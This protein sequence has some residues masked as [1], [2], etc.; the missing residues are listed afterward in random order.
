MFKKILMHIYFT[1]IIDDDN[2]N[3]TGKKEEERK[4]SLFEHSSL[5]ETEM[6]IKQLDF[7]IQSQNLKKNENNVTLE[8][9]NTVISPLL[10]E[11]EIK[12]LKKKK[13]IIYIYIYILLK[14]SN[15]NKFLI[16]I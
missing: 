2:I 14:I 12:V 1:F 11:I 4:E 7:L 9:L 10:S 15:I 6:T 5:K 8:K 3:I 13:K 16:L